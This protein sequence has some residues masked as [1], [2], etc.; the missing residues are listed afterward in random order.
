MT[1]WRISC[2]QTIDNELAASR[3]VC[4][5]YALLLRFWLLFD[6]DVLLDTFQTVS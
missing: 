1:Y 3:P 4:R 6:D 2:R 5:G